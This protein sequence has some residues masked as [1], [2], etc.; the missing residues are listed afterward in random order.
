L[1][2]F[3]EALFAQLRDDLAQLG[4]GKAGV[5]SQVREVHLAIHQSEDTQVL[6]R[7]P[8]ELILDFQQAFAGLGEDGVFVHRCLTGRAQYALL[9]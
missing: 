1:E 9:L 4:F 3:D 5:R 7:Q 8:I 2:L 6:A